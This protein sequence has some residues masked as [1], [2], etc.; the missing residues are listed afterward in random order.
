MLSTRHKHL[1]ARHSYVGIMCEKK[2]ILAT[3]IKLSI[4]S[5][6]LIAHNIVSNIKNMHVHDW[7]SQIC[8]ALFSSCFTTQ[9]S[10]KFID[11]IVFNGFSLF[12]SH[13]LSRI[14]CFLF[15]SMFLLCRKFNHTIGPHWLCMQK[16]NTKCTG[17]PIQW[18]SNRAKRKYGKR[19]QNDRINC[20]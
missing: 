11:A 4:F 5:T 9:N 16:G 12:R 3:H 1:I 19:V 14:W 13:S 6:A 17:K 15:S 8:C 10:Q 2:P 20:E 18:L 7:N